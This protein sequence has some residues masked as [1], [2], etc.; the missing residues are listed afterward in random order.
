M[1]MGRQ[2][3]LTIVSYV[4]LTQQYFYLEFNLSPFPVFPQQKRASTISSEELS[5]E[6]PESSSP[7]K[8]STC[9]T[10]RGEAGGGGGREVYWREKTTKQIC[11][12]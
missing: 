8:T 7:G 11:S 5:C 1:M 6:T 10:E 2:N 3:N 12:L 9:L 4:I